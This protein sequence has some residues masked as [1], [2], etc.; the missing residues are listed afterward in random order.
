MKL[1]VIDLNAQPI[2]EKELPKQFEEPLREDII[3]RAF[4]AYCSTKRQPY[5][6]FPEA[7]KRPSAKLSKRRRA[8]RGS[9]GYG[10]SRVQRKV[11]SARGRRMF[12]VGAFA[13]GTV[14]GR[15]AHP[16]KAQKDWTKK[17]NKAEAKKAIRSALAATLLK[18]CVIERGH[19]VPQNYPFLLDSA[20]ERINKTSQLKALLIK[21]GFENEINRTKTKKVR[22]GKGKA[23]GRKYKKKKGILIVVSKECPLLKA[24]R[25]VPGIDAVAVTDLNIDLL[26]PGAH[27]GRAAL[28]TT[29]AIEQLEKKALFT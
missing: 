14:K 29:A 18:E 17:I 1:K 26:A 6:A 4:L 27:P 10:I 23:R 24:G 8:Y 3:K 19:R 25:N 13:P 11:L 16:P 9:Y 15:R 22:A 7:G 5:G 20:A 28:F 21:L 12:W 2:G